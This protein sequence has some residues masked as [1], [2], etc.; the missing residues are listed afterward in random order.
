MTVIGG[1]HDSLDPRVTFGVY[2]EV[3]ISSS[4]TYSSLSGTLPP[5]LTGARS[6]NYSDDDSTIETRLDYWGTV[7][8]YRLKGQLVALG[9]VEER[10]RFVCDD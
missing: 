7:Q 1:R 9:A 6:L 5:S 2:G 8:Y 4:D 10:R 3:N